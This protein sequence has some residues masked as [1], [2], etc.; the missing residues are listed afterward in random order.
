MLS[1]V[2][3]AGAQR[4]ARA[5]LDSGVTT[6]ELAENGLGPDGAEALAPAIATLAEL[7][8]AAGGA[9]AGAGIGFA[10]GLGGDAGRLRVLVRRARDTLVAAAPSE[11][12]QR[13][14]P[15]LAAG[16]GFFPSD[17][18]GTAAATTP[19]RFAGYF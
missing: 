8:D 6:L 2:G 18:G 1:Q 17:G 4:L 3:P 11:R 7:D 15:L 16:G 5:C 10:G 12:A 13:T 14:A 9:A 19:T